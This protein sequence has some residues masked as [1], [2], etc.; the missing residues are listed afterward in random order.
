M[1][2]ATA[3][4]L[5]EVDLLR[6][7]PR[8]P[9]HP[10]RTLTPALAIDAQAHA[11]YWRESFAAVQDR[12]TKVVQLMPNVR[13]SFVVDADILQVFRPTRDPAEYWPHNPLCHAGLPQGPLADLRETLPI[14]G[15]KRKLSARER[16]LKEFTP[17]STSPGNA[18]RTIVTAS[19]KRL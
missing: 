13:A 19:G 10:P 1:S 12:T 6:L 17:M 3:P 18:P 16:A 5:T 4:A 14:A 15:R 9:Y 8:V 7:V 11:D 2:A